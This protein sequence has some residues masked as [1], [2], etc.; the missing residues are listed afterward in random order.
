MMIRFLIVALVVALSAAVGSAQCV[1]GVCYQPQP[2]PQF[3]VM[4]SPPQPMPSPAGWTPSAPAT[5]YPG[6]YAPRS[7]APARRLL[8]CRPV[9]GLVSFA[10][11][12]RCR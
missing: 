11:T 2:L 8:D 10:F 4:T 5:A 7:F 3:V 1:N 6:A 12:G 9:R